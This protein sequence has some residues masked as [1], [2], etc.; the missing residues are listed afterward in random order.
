MVDSI[1]YQPSLGSPLKHETD[2]EERDCGH[3]TR[4]HDA[5]DTATSR[6]RRTRSSAARHGGAAS[7][8]EKSD[9]TETHRTHDREE[10]P[11]GAI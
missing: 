9:T 6:G 3:D 8:C 5:T 1:E 10:P 11:V 4:Y 2:Y 7:E